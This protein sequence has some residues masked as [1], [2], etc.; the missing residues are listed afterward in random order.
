MNATSDEPNLWV[1]WTK[2]FQDEHL[3]QVRR[4]SRLP[5]LVQKAQELRKGATRSDVVFEL[6][7]IKLLRY[8]RDEPL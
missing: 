4:L 2:A 3:A 6:G 7:R 1:R 5:A 8:R